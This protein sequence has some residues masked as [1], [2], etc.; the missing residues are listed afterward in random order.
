MEV[1]LWGL[2]VDEVA[3]CCGAKIMD[4][5]IRSDSKGFNF[6]CVVIT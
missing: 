2:E 3:K 4:E 6:Q 5:G 1:Q